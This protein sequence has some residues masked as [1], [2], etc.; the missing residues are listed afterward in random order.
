VT[1][2]CQPRRFRGVLCIRLV[3]HSIHDKSNRATIQQIEAIANTQE[4]QK[5]NSHRRHDASATTVGGVERT[6]R[7]AATYVGKSCRC[8]IEN[9]GPLEENR[10]G[11][12]R[13]AIFAKSSTANAPHVIALTQQIPAA[14]ANAMVSVIMPNE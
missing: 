1:T 14:A 3:R 12:R 7:N 4:I 11:L 2:D 13:R 5:P 8:Q 6:K 9:R 10:S